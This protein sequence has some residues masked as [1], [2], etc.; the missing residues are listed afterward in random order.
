MAYH[1][2]VIFVESPVFTKQVSDLLSDDEYAAFQ[3]WLAANPKAGDVIRD[4]GGLRKARWSAGGKGKRSGVRV[5]YY[6]LDEL[7]QVRLLL[8]YRKGI[9][10]DLS[11]KEKAVLR[12]IKA[13]WTP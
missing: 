8:I 5:I 1:S 9:K 6:H 12:D 4:T 10:D 13:R 11:A 2:A 7:A 3:A